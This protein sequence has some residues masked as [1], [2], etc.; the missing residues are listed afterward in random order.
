MLDHTPHSQAVWE[1]LG[2]GLRMRL[3]S[4]K[5][6][7]LVASFPDHVGGGG[8]GVLGSGMRTRLQP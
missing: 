4:R 6:G 5:V 2:S 8:G 7:E 1:E 3:Y